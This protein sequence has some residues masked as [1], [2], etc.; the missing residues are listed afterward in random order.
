[1]LIYNEVTKKT[2]EFRTIEE[3]IVKMY[4]CGPTIY[5]DI[6]I[7]NARPIVFF[8]FVS[9]ILEK[10]GYKVIYV[11]NITDVD[12][13]I[14][15][16]AKQEHISEE[17]IIKK[18]MDKFVAVLNDLNINYFEQPRVTENIDDIINFIKHLVL[19][20]YA[21]VVEGD[22]YFNIHSIEKYGMI[23]N[24]KIEEN[25]QDTRSEKN[26]KKRNPNDFTLWKKTEIG[27]KWESP[28][29]YGRPGWHTECVVMIK[30]ILGDK[31]DIHG[32]GMDL[33]FPHHE[34][35][36]A[37]SLACGQGLATY[38]MH[39]G[40]INMDNQ[41][42]S[43]SIGNVFLAKDFIKKYSTNIL[44]LIMFQTSYRQPINLNEEFL[45]ATIKLEERFKNH[46]L[47]LNKVTP[48]YVSSKSLSIASN[49]FDSVNL[50]SHIIEMMKNSSEEN[51]VEFVT[52]ISLLN[53]KFNEEIIPIEIA[54]LIQKRNVAKENKDFV[55]SD[56][57]RKKIER[58]GYEIIDSRE[59]TKC[60]KIMR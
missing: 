50:I 40:F 35:E 36:N 30:N 2:E 51:D 6:H 29:S 17:E 26:R 52:G 7:G 19:E 49:D 55:L 54:D 5:S 3:K 34:N 41:K 57:I 12:D 27:I 1:M 46:F 8:D 37:Q 14:I 47:K 48:I 58:L 28:W 24:L 9:N 39:N 60:K 33:Q 18:N 15:N 10:N 43:K 32:G 11:S 44:R 13:K 25:I 38:W 45:K 4:V 53:L 21:Y 20:N 16:Q 31:I 59:G 42:M 23:S 56:E 22:V